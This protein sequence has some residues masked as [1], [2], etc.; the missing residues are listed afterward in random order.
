MKSKQFLFTLDYELY[1]DGSGDVL[2][3]VVEPTQRL[4]TIAREKGVRYTFFFEVVEYWCLKSEWERGNTMGY[5]RNPVEAMETQMRQA[6]AEGH[7]VQLHIHPQWC[8]A[9]WQD[10]RWVVDNS[11]WRLADYAGDMADLLRRGKKTLEEMLRP[12]KPDYR[13][14][15]LRAGGYNAY[16][17]ERIV[18]AMREVGLTVDS[19]VVPGAVENGALSRYDYRNSPIDRGFWSVDNRLEEPA[20]S[21]T[22]TGIIELPIVSLPIK[23]FTKYMSWSR[24]KAIMQNRKS[25]MASFDAKTS[26]VGSD[27]YKQGFLAKL[28]SRIEYMFQTEYQTWDFC[29]FSSSMHKKFLDKTVIVNRDVYTLVGHPK[30]LTND[31]N[32]FLFLID[33]LKNNY[34]DVVFNSISMIIAK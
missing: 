6:V 11:Q 4:L 19:S 23:R 29:L 9:M 3:N 25:A 17:S 22:D 34:S 14:I 28:W 20:D 27:S 33:C 2:R 18:Q 5:S 24:I 16:P 32:G 15:A 8:G 12:A 31:I 10:G 21:D 1:G 7:D 26:G 30:S 13:C